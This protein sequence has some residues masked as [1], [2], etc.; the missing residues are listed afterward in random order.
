MTLIELIVT[1]AIGLIVSAG[2]ASVFVF[3]M[4]QFTILVEKNQAEE[5]A[6]LMNY[7]LRRFLSQ[8]VDMNAMS[9]IDTSLLGSG[10][11]QIDINFE[12]LNPSQAGIASG[13]TGAFT[14]FAIF[15]REAAL[16]NTGANQLPAGGSD[17]RQTGIFLRDTNSQANAILPDESSGAII[18]DIHTDPASPMVPSANDMF[19]TRLHNFR[20]QRVNCN[21]SNGFAV[22]VV[23]YANGNILKCLPSGWAPAG[24]RFRVKTIT[25]ETVTRYFRSA[26]KG[27][28]NYRAPI[29]GPPA[30][31]YRDIIQTI[32]IN[33][34]N[35]GL[36][37]QSL[38]GRS[39][40]EE[41]VFGSVYFYDYFI[42]ST[43][44]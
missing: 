5:N 18:F 15:N 13:D 39:G 31:P 27:M 17:I 14:R 19:L 23:N 37:D 33:M 6:L 36:T 4:Q 21:G 30:A 29:G 24:G 43:R 44:N 10:S 42:P 12:L 11:G 25:V 9:A 1:I 3:A 41:R 8:A 34:K 38:T 32:K 7:Y 22:E 40:R 28:W 20:V 2:I 26:N 16:Y 35:N